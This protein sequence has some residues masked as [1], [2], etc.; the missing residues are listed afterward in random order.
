VNSV[1]EQETLMQEFY[2]YKIPEIR[3]FLCASNYITID[4]ASYPYQEGV[5]TAVGIATERVELLRLVY[6]ES[7]DSR[8]RRKMK[9]ILLA[10]LSK[11]IV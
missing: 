6:S 4:I 1:A 8:R 9:P 11:E 2:C 3:F 5:T 7:C 10:T